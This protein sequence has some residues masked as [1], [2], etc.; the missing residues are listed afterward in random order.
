MRRSLKIAA[1]LWSSAVL[2]SPSLPA[3]AATPVPSAVS[4]P[5]VTILE[6]QAQDPLVHD[7]AVV[8]AL[9]EAF[10]ATFHK[11][12]PKTDQAKTLLASSGVQR[13]P[14]FFIPEKGLGA[15]AR[16][17]LE[18]LVANGMM[19]RMPGYFFAREDK[20]PESELFARDRIAGRL[21]VFVM[22]QCPFANGALRSLAYALQEKKLP[23]GTT[24]SVH[25]LL[26]P[27]CLTRTAG[28][29]QV[30][31]PLQSS[32]GLGEVEEDIRQLVIKKFFPDQWG[33]YIF[34]RSYDFE[35]SYWDEAAR[36]AG[37][38]EQAVRGKARSDEGKA[39]LR[40]DG[41]L[42]AELGIAASPTFLWENRD[43]LSAE[44]L[45]KVLGITLESTGS[46]R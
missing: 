42:A 26:S 15:A 31:G 46:C 40:E 5:V 32:H 16:R 39:L 22:S 2:I 10:Q 27:L 11:L 13:L 44:S 30:S 21:D 25:Y 41:K 4:R 34:L 14:A 23:A 43:L 8:K 38:D 9:E 29:I 35:S 3:Q 12:D 45:Q 7:Q 17:H 24:L 36:G 6:I 33:R 19:A 20:V 28:G 37:L 1:C 18:L